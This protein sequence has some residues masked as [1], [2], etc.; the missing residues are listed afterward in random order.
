MMIL[1][2]LRKKNNCESVFLIKTNIFRKKT[3][4]FKKNIFKIQI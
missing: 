3:S 2:N 4:I 1:C